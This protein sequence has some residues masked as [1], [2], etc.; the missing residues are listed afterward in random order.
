MTRVTAIEPGPTN[1]V[2]ANRE[3]RQPKV[4][5]NEGGSLDTAILVAWGE[6]DEVF[7]GPCGR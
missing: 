2:V 4:L 3:G 7:V 1:N 6:K 5:V